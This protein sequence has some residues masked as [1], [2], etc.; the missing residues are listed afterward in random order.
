[1]LIL[2]RAAFSVR[3]AIRAQG[4]QISNIEAKEG[5]SLMDAVMESAP[6]KGE[7]NEFGLCGGELSCHTCR[8]D[9]ITGYEK[10]PEPLV[11]EEDVFDQL[12]GLYRKGST[13]MA[14]QVKVTKQLEG[15]LI[16]IPRE[17]WGDV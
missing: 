11:E 4:G 14:C 16:E 9:F 15:A 13:R 17:A 7:L 6:F 2:K 3:F 10:L 1:M 12:A 5:S 8:V